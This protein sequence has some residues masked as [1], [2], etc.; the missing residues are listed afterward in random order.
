ME[1]WPFDHRCPLLFL[2]NF[3]GI[4]M[5]FVELGS[6]PATAGEPLLEGVFGGLSNLETLRLDGNNLTGLPEEIF[7]GLSKLRHQK[8]GHNSLNS[9]MRSQR[10]EMDAH[11]RAFSGLEGPENCRDAPCRLSDGVRCAGL[12]DLRPEACTRKR[13][14]I[15]CHKIDRF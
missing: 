7:S 5:R 6:I 13:D 2:G 9:P 12:P 1:T 3:Y 4:W 11:G 15:R 10:D 14:P 8:M